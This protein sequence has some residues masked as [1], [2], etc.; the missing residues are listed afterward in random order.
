VEKSKTPS[1][2]TPYR[3]EVDVLTALCDHLAVALVNVDTKK[4]CL[5]E[6]PLREALS[7]LSSP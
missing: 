6:S 2:T 4:Q 1:P 7:P 5:L 3:G